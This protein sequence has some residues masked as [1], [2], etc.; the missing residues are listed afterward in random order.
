MDRRPL[1]NCPETARHQSREVPFVSRG[2]THKPMEA[3]D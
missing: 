1:A 2:V 3:P